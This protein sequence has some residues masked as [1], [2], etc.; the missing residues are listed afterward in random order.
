MDSL[1]LGGG[2]SLVRDRDHQIESAVRAHE[3]FV[4]ALALRLAP[5]PGLAADIA[6]QVFLEFVEKRDIWDLS[7]D[8]K[9]LLAGMTRN[10]AQRQWRQRS[11]A[12]AP[13]MIALAEKVR[14]LTENEEV[15]WYTEEEK[16]AL[17]QCL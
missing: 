13:E 2:S 9:P 15:P 16:A 8:L 14:S 4:K 5:I 6:Q 7:A 17:R 1:K 10:V 11:K 3:P 12:M